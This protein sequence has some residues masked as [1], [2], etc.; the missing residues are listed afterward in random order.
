MK[1]FVRNTVLSAGF[2]LQILLKR[3]EI[4]PLLHSPGHKPKPIVVFDIQHRQ[5][6]TIYYLQELTSCKPDPRQFCYLCSPKSW[7]WPTTA[8]REGKT[9]LKNLIVSLNVLSPVS[10]ESSCWQQLEVVPFTA[11]QPTSSISKTGPNWRERVSPQDRQWCW[12]Q[13]VPSQGIGKHPKLN[14]SSKACFW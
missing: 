5:Q 4:C 12:G 13:E 14:S 10:D 2:Q 3:S 9:S 11:H 6:Q 1:T 8:F 7:T